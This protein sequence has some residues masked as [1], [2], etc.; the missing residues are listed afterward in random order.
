[1][2]WAAL[3]VLVVIGSLLPAASTPMQTIAALHVNDKALHLIA[4]V[5]LA[6]LPA[7]YERRRRLAYIAARLVALGVSLEFGQLWSPG[8]SFEIGD[9]VADAAGAIAGVSI[10]LW[11]RPRVANRLARNEG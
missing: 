3:I 11:S 8:R 2:V 4:Y 10:G 1:V 5:S 7:L 6:F 9:M